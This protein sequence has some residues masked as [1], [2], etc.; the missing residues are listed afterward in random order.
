MIEWNCEKKSFAH[1]ELLI[2]KNGFD[3]VQRNIEKNSPMSHCA[4][5]CKISFSLSSNATVKMKIIQISLGSPH[6]N[7]FFS[8][9]MNLWHSFHYKIH[10]RSEIFRSSLITLK[11]KAE[12]PCFRFTAD[13]VIVMMLYSIEETNRE[14]KEKK[15]DTMRESE[16]FFSSYKPKWVVIV[17]SHAKETRSLLSLFS[18]SPSFASYFRQIT[19]LLAFSSHVKMKLKI[20]RL[21]AEF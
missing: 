16:S 6:R 5:L 10:R 21:V 3:E 9:V 12:A 14:R 15:I 2:L 17:I 7:S 13:E 8:F 19:R 20:L 4:D 11:I 1:T 18:I